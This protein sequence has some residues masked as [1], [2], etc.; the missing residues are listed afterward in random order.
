MGA[1]RLQEGCN[2]GP[3]ILVN[4]S[5]NPLTGDFDVQKGFQRWGDY[6]AITLDPLDPQTVYGVNEK[7][8]TSSNPT[9]WQSYIFNGTLP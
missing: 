2:I 9:V 8:F 4:Q 6:S 1:K 7:V 3:G 5:A